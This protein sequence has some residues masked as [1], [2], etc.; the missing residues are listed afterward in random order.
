VAG[1]V[2]QRIGSARIIWAS[3]VYLGWTGLLVPLATPGWGVGLYALGWTC[4]S[5]TATFY[6]TGQLSFRQAVCPPE[7]LGRMNASVRWVIWGINPLGAL[8]GGALGAWLGVRPTLWIAMACVWSSGWWVF[9]S[10]LRRMR[11][12]PIAESSEQ[13]ARP[14][15]PND[16]R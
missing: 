11:D 5:A 4:F 2:A 10:P 6:N 9:F 1:R 15:E 12:I 13:L 14:K 7:L 3:F 16:H 8:L